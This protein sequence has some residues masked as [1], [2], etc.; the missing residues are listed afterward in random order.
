MLKFESINYIKIILKLMLKMGHYK[1]MK[2]WPK[3]DQKWSV[4][5]RPK[6]GQKLICHGGVQND[7]NRQIS[8]SGTRDPIFINFLKFPHF[9]QKLPHFSTPKSTPINGLLKMSF[10]TNRLYFCSNGGQKMS[11]FGGS[12]GGPLGPKIVDTT[13]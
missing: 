10:P 3:N 9:L 13:I 11:L 7:K 5:N 6:N 2:K 8:T 12:G 1:L 4:I